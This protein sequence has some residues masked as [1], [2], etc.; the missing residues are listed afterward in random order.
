MANGL[1]GINLVRCWVA[2]RVLPLSIRPGLICEYIGE[3]TDPQLHCNTEM[4]EEDI[5]EMT[6]TL[7]NE[8]IEDC[9]KVG[10]APFCVLN[11][12]PAVSF[13]YSSYLTHIFIFAASSYSFIFYRP[14]HPSGTRN[15]PKNQRNPDK[16]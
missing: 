15:C 8:S 1:T 3:L 14:T 11:K 10:L 13:E 12:L 6:K 9:S 5:N 4:I 16:E 7:L 2:W